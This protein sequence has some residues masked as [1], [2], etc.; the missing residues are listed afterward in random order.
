MRTSFVM[1]VVCVLVGAVYAQPGPDLFVPYV[2]PAR[3][4]IDG[5]GT[6]WEDPEVCTL[7]ILCF[8]PRMS[9]GTSES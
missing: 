7:R 3:I 9:P 8:R 1:V 2:D 4:T 5:L 6:D